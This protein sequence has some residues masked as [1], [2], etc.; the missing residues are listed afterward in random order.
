VS[1]KF[2]ET[3]VVFAADECGDKTKENTM[4]A[5]KGFLP[6][7]SEIVGIQKNRYD[8]DPTTDCKL[9][10]KT[11]S[12]NETVKLFLKDKNGP[13]GVWPLFA[14]CT[15]HKVRDEHGKIIKLAELL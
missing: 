4:E 13:K 14:C 6:D 15:D 9:C 1:C 12:A 10:H 8:G 2:L 3:A 5:C 7:G 11:V